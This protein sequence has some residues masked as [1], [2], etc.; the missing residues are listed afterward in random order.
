MQLTPEQQAQSQLYLMAIKAYA[1]HIRLTEFPF[2]PNHTCLH[3]APDMC[4]LSIEHEFQSEFIN[5]TPDR[6]TVCE[7]KPPACHIVLAK[8]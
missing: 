5:D 6:I 4:W 1:E 7:R 3:L 2:L 8:L